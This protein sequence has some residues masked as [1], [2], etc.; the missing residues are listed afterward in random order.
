MNF[1]KAL[2]FAA[3]LSGAIIVTAPPPAMAQA[4][5]TLSGVWRGVYWGG[6]NQ[7]TQFQATLRQTGGALSGSIVEDNNFSAEHIPFLLA[8]ISGSANGDTVSFTKTYD[9][10]GG[11]SHTVNYTGRI[12]SNGRRIAGTWSIGATSG[13][14]ELA[15]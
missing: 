11:A 14:F 3:A 6:D 1:F 9:G 2:V 15:R 12:L 5:S 13:Q 10:T 8:T 7:V 4:S